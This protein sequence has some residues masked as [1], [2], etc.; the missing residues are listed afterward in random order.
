VS[1]DCREDLWAVGAQS[2]KKVAVVSG[3]WLTKAG[4]KG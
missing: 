3:A 2:A 1:A 4:I